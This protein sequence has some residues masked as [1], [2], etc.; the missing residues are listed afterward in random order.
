[1]DPEL[2][3]EKK[4]T[5]EGGGAPPPEADAVPA[6]E[7]TPRESENA[8]KFEVGCL[9]DAASL[10]GKLKEARQLEGGGRPDIGILGEPSAGPD[11]GTP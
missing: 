10:I 7:R 5:A 2:E 9:E 11:P 6:T 4:E 8:A 1:M 3:S